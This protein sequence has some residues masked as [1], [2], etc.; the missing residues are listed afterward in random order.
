MQDFQSALRIDP[1]DKY[2]AIWRYIANVRTGGDGTAEL[3][4]FA[5]AH[6]KDDE[7]NAPIVHLFL[8]RITP[9]QCLAA[10]EDKNPKTT[11]EQKCEAYFY[12]G[13]YYLLQDNEQNAKYY[14][15]C[16]FEVFR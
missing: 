13:Q 4:T 15:A 6:V 5:N 1:A 12:A 2:V 9:T 16:G 3:R 10:A 7:W 11:K 14:S 8:G